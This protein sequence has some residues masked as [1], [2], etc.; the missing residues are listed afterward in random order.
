MPLPSNRRGERTPLNQYRLLLAREHL[1]TA[2][3]AVLEA[4]ATLNVH[5]PNF[6]RKVI[7]LEKAI[8][9]LCETI[10]QQIKE[11]PDDAHPKHS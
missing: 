8:V 4:H 1:A 2:H 11:S 10:T 3:E 5:H 9:A 7:R 6:D